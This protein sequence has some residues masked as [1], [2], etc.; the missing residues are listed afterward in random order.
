MP[1]ASRLATQQ[2]LA[3]LRRSL[4]ERHTTADDGV[5]AKEKLGIDLA[6]TRMGPQRFGHGIHF[7][8]HQA[9]LIAQTA[10]VTQ[11][12]HDLAQGAGSAAVRA[13]DAAAP[14]LLKHNSNR[15]D[16]LRRLCRLHA[17]VLLQE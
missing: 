4:H 6:Q 12:V 13:A 10:A 5:I 2:F 16:V 9:D 15:T 3:L 8:A 14:V 7:A 1:S 11:A 17:A